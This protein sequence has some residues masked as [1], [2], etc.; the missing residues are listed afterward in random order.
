M[1]R[2]RS[3]RPDLQPEKLTTLLFHTYNHS[4]KAVPQVRDRGY[5]RSL[6]VAARLAVLVT[7]REESH[8]QTS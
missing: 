1:L 5:E 2:Q 8:G 4:L 7:L 6:T 3:V